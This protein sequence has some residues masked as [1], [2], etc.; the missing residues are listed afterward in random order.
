MKKEQKFL[1]EIL[2]SSVMLMSA[3]SI[4][5]QQPNIVFTREQRVT[6]GP[7][8]Q[9]GP[10]PS[11]QTFVYV[12][13]EIFDG[14]LVKGAPYSAQAVTEMTQTLGDGNRIV[15]KSTSAVYRDSEGRTRREHTLRAIGPFASAGEAPLTISISDPVAGINYALDPRT[16]VAHKMSPMRFEFKVIGPDHG[17]QT[18]GAANESSPGRSEMRIRTAPALP[19]GPEGGEMT[20]QVFMRTPALAQ[21][22]GMVMELHGSGEQKG[23]TE[24]LGKQTI[25]GIEAEGNRTVITIP[26]GEIGNERPIEIVSER[27]YSPELQVVVMTK[28]S[29]PRFGESSY[30]LTNIDRSDPAKSLFEVPADYT[31]QSTG[32]GIGG[33]DPGAGD[34]LSSKARFSQALATSAPINGGVLNG[35]AISLPFPAYPAIARQAG[36]AGTVTVEVIMDEDGNVT[37][38]RATSGHPLLQAA[39]VDA[40]RKA[41]FAPT[42]LSGQPVKVQ[43]VVT[44]TFNLARNPQDE[45]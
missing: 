16:K 42:K 28:H 45:Q 38:A 27:W 36:A 35:K 26:A 3:I 15:N 39:A 8:G 5:A 1:V 34:N 6:Q 7:D 9:Q 11:D 25:E 30:R 33:F 13:S 41:K 37:A 17:G 10:P 4:F 2:F 29:D 23:K 21:A 44:Y 14:K 20:S 12:A 43:G 31:I 19:P 22:G 40:A 24:S 18:P 32:R